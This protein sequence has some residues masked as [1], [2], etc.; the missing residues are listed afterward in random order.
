MKLGARIF[1]HSEENCIADGRN[2]T[3][4][5]KLKYKI[6]WLYAEY[7][8]QCV[9]YL[10]KILMVYAISPEF[11]QIGGHEAKCSK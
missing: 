7:I 3:I 10:N 6:V 9:C 5:Y 1:W 2:R 8:G 11:I 4:T